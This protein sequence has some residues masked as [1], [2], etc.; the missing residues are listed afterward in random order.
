MQVGSDA[1][2]NI[3]L[4]NTSGRQMLFG[5]R[6]G[7]NNPE[8][9]FRIEVRSAAGHAVEETAY[10]RE[11]LQHQQEESRTVDYL[12]PGQ[13]V[14]QTAHIEKLVELK[15][16]GRYTVQ[17]SKKDAEKGVVVRSNEVVLNVVP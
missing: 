17:V 6:P 15:R 9:S 10:G 14:V 3:T 5:H 2:V 11:A 13:T 16:P 12:Q 7:A 1:R 4:T 8:F